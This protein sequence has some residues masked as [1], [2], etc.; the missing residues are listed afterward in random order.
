MNPTS[1][2]PNY[3]DRAVTYIIRTNHKNR[4]EGKNSYTLGTLVDEL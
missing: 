1:T 4:A 3:Y 2:D